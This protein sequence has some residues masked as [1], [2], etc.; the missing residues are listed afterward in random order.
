MSLL[1]VSALCFS[2]VSVWIS[3]FVSPSRSLVRLGLIV[4]FSQSLCPSLCPLHECSRQQI[5]GGDA[6]T[7]PRRRPILRPVSP[8]PGSRPHRSRPRFPE[9][10][11]GGVPRGQLPSAPLPGGRDPSPLTSPEP[12]PRADKSGGPAEERSAGARG[13]QRYGL[14]TCRLRTPS[15]RI[16]DPSC[17][18]HARQVTAPTPLLPQAASGSTGKGALSARPRLRFSESFLERRAGAQAG[19]ALAPPFPPRA[20]AGDPTGGA[21]RA[22]RW[23]SLLGTQVR[24]GGAQGGSSATPPDRVRPDRSGHSGRRREKLGVRIPISTLQIEF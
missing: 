17:G 20:P 1:C 24:G 4:C 10:Q 7:T 13:P 2:V 23:R 21:A 19:A 3:I 14:L 16:L 22:H 5:S 8:R 18:A 9:E 6:E 11:S 15:P 12:P